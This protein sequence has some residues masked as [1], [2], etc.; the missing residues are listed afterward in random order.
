MMEIPEG[1]I[2][3]DVIRRLKLPEEIS[4]L[5]VVNGEVRQAVHPLEDGDEI[6]LFPPIA[7]GE[8]E[9]LS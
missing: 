2:L 3:S 8:S 9:S 7:G 6:A 5:K 1:S 4:L